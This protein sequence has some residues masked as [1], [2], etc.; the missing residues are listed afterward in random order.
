MEMSEE[1]LICELRTCTNWNITII[2]LFKINFE[3]FQ[4]VED[5]VNSILEDCRWKNYTINIR[6]L[7]KDFKFHN[8]SNT[9]LPIELT[10][11]IRLLSLYTADDEMTSYKA[12]TIFASDNMFGAN[13]ITGNYILVLTDIENVIRDEVVLKYVDNELKR[14]KIHLRV[15]EIIL[16][17]ER[18]LLSSKVHHSNYKLLTRSKDNLGRVSLIETYDILDR[19]KPCPS[20]TN[21]QKI[22]QYGELLK[23]RQI[24]WALDHINDFIIGGIIVL[25]AILAGFLAALYDLWN[26]KKDKKLIKS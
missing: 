13:K 8:I 25:I 15:I 3:K 16:D 9:M 19:V 26:K 21:L 20:L 5:I 18:K 23:E 10:P 12:S 17:T 22:H 24:T 2:S 1:N 11:E 6:F 4:I 7:T 14:K